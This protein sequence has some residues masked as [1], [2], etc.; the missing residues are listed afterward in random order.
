[1]WKHMTWRKESLESLANSQES[2]QIITALHCQS[3]RCLEPQDAAAMPC[4]KQDCSIAI[5]TNSCHAPGER[6]HVLLRTDNTAQFLALTRTV[7]DCVVVE[8]KD[9][10]R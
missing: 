3:T 10:R 7:I 5:F 9:L 1:M 8:D 2:F 6:R 4:N